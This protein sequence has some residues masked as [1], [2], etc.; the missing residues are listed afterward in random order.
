MMEILKI[1]GNERII[2]ALRHS[3]IE[4]NGTQNTGGKTGFWQERTGDQLRHK[5]LCIL[6]QKPVEFL[7]NKSNFFSS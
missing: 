1:K 4:E 3:K 6:V 5:Q 7:S 2:E